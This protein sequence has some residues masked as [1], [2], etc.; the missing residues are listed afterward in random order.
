MKLYYVTRTYLLNLNTSL[1]AFYLSISLYDVNR[2]LAV[3]MDGSNKGRI[4]IVFKCPLEL[5]IKSTEKGKLKQERSN[6]QYIQINYSSHQV[7][8]C[9]TTI[10]FALHC[11]DSPLLSN[12]SIVVKYC[13]CCQLYPLLRL[14]RCSHCLRGYCFLS[15][16][17]VVV[18]YPSGRTFVGWRTLS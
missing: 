2:D 16:V 11:R 14:Y 10:A 13:D 17:D 18:L 7:Y 8:C 1:Y 5:F 15:P 4:S 3:F 6:I 12:V 9:E